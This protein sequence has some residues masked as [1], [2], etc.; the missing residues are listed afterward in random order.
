MI[1]LT[2]HI[3]VRTQTAGICEQGAN[4]VICTKG[5]KIIRGWRKLHNE[6]LQKSDSLC[7]K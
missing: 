3:K 6:E 7:W 5:D 1:I 2:I 4:D